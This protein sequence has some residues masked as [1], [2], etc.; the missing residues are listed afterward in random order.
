MKKNR[1]ANNNTEVEEISN[2]IIMQDTSFERKR[3]CR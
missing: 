1:I 3:G 2:E